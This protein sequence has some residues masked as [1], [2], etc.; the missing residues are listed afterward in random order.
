MHNDTLKAGPDWSNE[1]RIFLWLS[2]AYVL[3]F[4][5]SIDLLGQF[6]FGDTALSNASLIFLPHG[7]RVIAAWL[8]G[9]KAILYIMPASYITHVARLDYPFE[10]WQVGL[11][12][13]IGVVCAVIVFE[14]LARL[15]TDLRLRPGYLTSWKNVISV[16]VLASFV[17]SVGTNLAYENDIKH[18][19]AYFVG[20]VIGM[21]ALMLLMMLAF[22][23]VRKRYQ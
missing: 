22:R 20:D 8:Y 12:P 4:W 10:S 16:G 1:L 3:T 6:S 19:A 23:A 21:I 9:W 5:I 18:V 14:L 7:V 11:S 2:T 15:G 17:N 13:I